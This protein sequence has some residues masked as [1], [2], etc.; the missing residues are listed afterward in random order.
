[1]SDPITSE[2]HD[3]DEK[4]MRSIEEQIGITENQKRAF[5][6][7]IL[8]KIS[9]YARRGRQFEYTSHE[10]LKDAIEKK[11]FADLKDV[12]K[13]T[14]STI[15]PD[16]AQVKRMNEVSRRLI[17]HNGYCATCANELMKYVGS[18][19]NR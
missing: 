1:M 13:I 11:L 12:I 5:R 9:S 16:E 3:P 15:N 8:I 2:E 17:E 19:L 7:E 14:T 10:P 4:L 18:L 6:E